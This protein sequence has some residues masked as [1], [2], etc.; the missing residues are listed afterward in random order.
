MNEDAP[1]S[2]DQEAQSQPPASD[3]EWEAQEIYFRGL[4]V[5]WVGMG[6]E[7]SKMVVAQLQRSHAHEMAR[8]DNDPDYL[9]ENPAK[10][11]N[12]FIGAFDH[13]QRVNARNILLCRRLAKPS[14]PRE[15]RE[16]KPAPIA[17][18]PK[19]PR[20]EIPRPDSFRP[21]RIDCI[22]RIDRIDSITGRSIAG[23]MMRMGRGFGIFGLQPDH[24]LR[25]ELADDI[26]TLEA[27]AIDIGLD[28]NNLQPIPDPPDP[29]EYPSGEYPSGEQSADP[30]PT[31]REPP[32]E[33]HAPGAGHAPSPAPNPHPTPPDTT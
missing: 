29:D 23:M 25:Q 30:D 33:W 10:D 32:T 3:D 17:A 7:I 5:K 1:L 20:P 19:P 8:Y 16:R 14:R 2:S 12:A 6:D 26:A 4:L 31:S 24:P 11:I 15:P 9:P 22:D 21:E 28:P 27:R 13:I 18:S